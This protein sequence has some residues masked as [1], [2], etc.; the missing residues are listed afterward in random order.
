MSHLPRRERLRMMRSA[1]RRFATIPGLREV[2]YGRRLRRSLQQPDLG[3]VFGVA[4]K[5]PTRA[6]KKSHRLPK[7]WKGFGTDVVE[8]GPL[9]SLVCA[10]AHPTYSLPLPHRPGIWIGAPGRCNWGSVAAFLGDQQ[11][12]VYALTARHVVRAY[13]QPLLGSRVDLPCQ[14]NGRHLKAIAGTVVKFTD[15]DPEFY[16]VALIEID[17]ADRGRV[18]N[19]CY[20]SNV[21]I[22]RHSDADL[23]QLV[24]LHAAR[25]AIPGESL[26]RVAATP[27]LA[28]R[29]G[30]QLLPGDRYWIRLSLSAAK[31]DSGGLVAT[32]DGACALGIL[33]V[34]RLLGDGSENYRVT[35]ATPFPQALA[36][37][38]RGGKHV[39]SRPGYDSLRLS[40]L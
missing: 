29:D 34:G 15:F 32:D 38:E 22:A 12:R 23:D 10:I 19:R 14:A 39:Q 24:S 21:A 26:G 28:I 7:T 20:R 9:R 1:T 37:L 40:L 2:G 5:L 18:T 13:E 6:L 17:A 16:D 36:D 4:S 33:Q 30:G 31:G 11:G 27:V 35:Y 25:T 3:L 8:L